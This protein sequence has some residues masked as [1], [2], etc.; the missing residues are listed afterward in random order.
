MNAERSI[1][2]KTKMRNASSSSRNN[3]TDSCS[4]VKMDTQLYGPNSSL[5]MFQD[6]LVQ[7]NKMLMTRAQKIQMIMSV[8]MN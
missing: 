8:V 4:D 5:K 1:R 6:Q 3:S 7:K 2:T